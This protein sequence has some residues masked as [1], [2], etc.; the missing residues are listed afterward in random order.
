MRLKGAGNL[1]V[2]SIQL[3]DTDT[4]LTHAIEVVVVSGGVSSY[5]T[6]SDGYYEIFTGAT[7]YNGGDILVEG[8]GNF[9]ILNLTPSVATVSTIGEITRHTSGILNVVVKNNFIS[10]PLSINLTNKND[11]SSTPR[12]LISTVVG[13]LA[14]HCQGQIDSRIDNT[15]TKGVNGLVYSTQNHTTS[16]YTRNSSLWC[17]DVNLTC[18]SP[19]NSNEANKKAGTLVTPRHILGAAHYEVNVNNIIRFVETGGTVHTRTIVGKRTHPNYTPYSP[20]LTIY[21][22]DSD[23]PP[24]ITPCKVMPSDWADYLVNNPDT[25]PPALGLDQEEK[26]LI[27]DFYGV[28]TGANFQYPIDSD[29]LIFSEELVGG[30]SGNPAFFIIG[31]ELVLITVWTFGGEGSGTYVSR[32]LNDLNQMIVDSDAQYGISTIGNV[33]WPNAGG[34][35]QLKIADLST[36]PNYS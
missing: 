7:Y 26:A 14:E 4:S 5:D 21:T 20:D 3:N 30:D 12:S 17:S 35:Y 27:M 13:S 28:G 33:T 32:F 8:M 15:M 11:G 19:W 29:R 24:E 2:R 31:G 18:I 23:L 25:R 34:H 22:L 16:T 6:I 9:E 1:V 36:F 10:I